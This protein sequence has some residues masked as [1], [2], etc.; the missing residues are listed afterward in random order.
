MIKVLLYLVYLVVLGAVVYSHPWLA[1]PVLAGV[2]AGWPA[3]R[4]R[5]EGGRFW[6]DVK[7]AMSNATGYRQ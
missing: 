5:A 3:G 2:V 7:R 6:D 4:S 1:V